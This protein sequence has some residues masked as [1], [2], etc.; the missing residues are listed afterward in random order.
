MSRL[1]IANHAKFVILQLALMLALRLPVSG[2]TAQ[3]NRVPDIKA[4]AD[5]TNGVYKV[6]EKVRF[7]IEAVAPELAAEDAKTAGYSLKLNNQSTITNGTFN[8]ISGKKVEYEFKNPGWVLLYVT[9]KWKDAE[10]KTVTRL[11]GA[12]CEPEKIRPGEEMPADFRS[13]WDKK[14]KILDAMPFEPEL[15][16]VTNM[17]N[18]KVETY[19]IILKNINGTKIRGF[20]A[21]PKG[22]GKFPAYMA[23]HAA[24]VYGIGPDVVFGYANRGVIAIDIN[25]HD[26]LNGQPK[27]YY[28]QLKLTG[29]QLMGRESREESYFLRMFC[30]CYRAAQYLTGRDEWDGKHFV[31]Y[32]GSQ[33]GGQ[34]FV[35]AS[36]CP[37]VTAFAAHVPA[38]CDHGGREAG[39]EAG[40]PRWVAYGKDGKPE[41]ASL[42]ASRYYDCAN[43]AQNIKAKALVSAGFIDCTCPPCSVYAAFNMLPGEKKMINMVATGHGANYEFSKELSIFINK[44][45]GLK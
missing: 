33:G 26:I 2:E 11:A 40:W 8:L 36:L 44:E 24:G 30:S 16:P 21:K 23:V 15:T 12:M 28:E 5:C 43:F 18:D 35:T 3:T 27:E 39:R 13:F 42:E 32:G 19:A 34:A 29:Y 1:I 37:K 41:T 38:L 17:T 14:K 22:A 31:V 20:F 9:P 6:G 4:I 10:G 25:A 45:L 7:K